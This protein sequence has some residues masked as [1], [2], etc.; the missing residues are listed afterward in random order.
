MNNT[1]SL[2]V[3]NGVR[4]PRDPFAYIAF[5]QLLTFI[6]LL[7]LIW[8][9]ELKDMQSFFFKTQAEGFNLFRASILS[10]GVFLTAILTIGNTYLQQRRVLNA[11]LAVC[12]KCHRVRI[13]ANVWKQMEDYV[14]ENSLLSFTHGLCPTC[15]A[16][17][18]EEMKNRVPK[19]EPS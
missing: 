3:S 9:N 4:L 13:R 11:L 2:D 10:A 14:S 18:I 1:P 12:F 17:V 8:L 16:E 7:L 5:W 15:M 19:Q 6:M